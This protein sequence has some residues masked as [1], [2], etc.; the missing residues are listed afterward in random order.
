MTIH[1]HDPPGAPRPTGA[2]SL[3][4]QAPPGI[5][6]AW[7]SGQTG[8]RDDGSYP[9]SIDD[10]TVVALDSLSA[11]IAGIG[12]STREILAFRVYLV[13]RENMEGFRAARD[14]RLRSWYPQGDYPASTLA[15][16]SGLAHPSAKVEIEAIVGLTSDDREAPAPSNELF[17]TS[18]D[19]K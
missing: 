13:G 9:A 14:S 16:V 3:V 15:L 7:L 2:Y 17:D 6:L 5:S 11:L 1:R 18:P 12:A 8:R 4:A 10:Q 19:T